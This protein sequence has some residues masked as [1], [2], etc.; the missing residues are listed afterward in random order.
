MYVHLHSWLPLIWW[1][2]CWVN[3]VGTAT[4]FSDFMGSSV[5]LKNKLS[6]FESREWVKF[7]FSYFGHYDL[8]ELQL[9][10][11]LG[12]WSRAGVCIQ[13][14]VRRRW[15]E[16]DIGFLCYWAFLKYWTIKLPEPGR[17]I[18]RRMWLPITISIS[19]GANLL[20]LLFLVWR[21][22]C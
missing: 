2:R 4:F 6:P 17:S 7:W 14:R 1:M 18:W 11:E 22:Y 13:S 19:V 9:Y 5:W 12:F 3:S 8:E 21:E 20:D 15:S 16:W 10:H